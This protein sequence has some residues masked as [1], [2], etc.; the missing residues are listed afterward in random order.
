MSDEYLKYARRLAINNG[1]QDGRVFIL[2]SV[3]FFYYFAAERPD[4]VRPVIFKWNWAIFML[5]RT[6]GGKSQRTP[7][8]KK[9]WSY[10][11]FMRSYVS[12][13]RANK[14]YLQNELSVLGDTW[15]AS[16][17]LASGPADK[18]V[19]NLSRGSRKNGVLRCWNK[20]QMKP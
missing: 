10:R 6:C 20:L 13:C 15:F 7:T 11:R 1:P 9:N 4:R 5:C 12:F 2:F 3:Y 19:Q 17:M 14:K 16:T 18:T 8:R